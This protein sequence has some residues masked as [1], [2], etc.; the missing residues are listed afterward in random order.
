MRAVT[1]VPLKPGSVDLTDL[2]EPPESDGPVL[3]K[4]RAIGVCGTDLEII[5]GEYG[6][7]P[8]GE[9]RLGIGHESLGEVLDAPPDSGFSAGDLVVGI[10][11]RPDPVPCPNCAVGEWDMCRNGKY[12]EWGIKEHHGFARERYRITPEF[13]VKIDS[14]LG[15]LGV[16]LEPTTILAKAWDH[17]ERIGARAVWSPSTALIIGAG[18]IGLLAALL[19]RQRG[20]EVHVLDQVPEGLK[21]DLVAAL[22]ATY[23]HGS[24]AD[25]GISPDVAIECTGVGQLIFDVMDTAGPNGIVCLTGVSSGGRELSLDVGTLNR[26]MVLEND[27]VFGSVNANHRHY[28]AGADALSNAD[29]EWLSRLITRRV[30]LS[31]WRGAYE[32]KPTD[33]KVVLEFDPGPKR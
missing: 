14:S 33:V 32:R 4:T 1:V 7:P 22:G 31:D 26:R 20:L 11:R 5:N 17:I 28:Q 9:E 13:L 15:N 25:V 19:G 8:P 27:V 2:P 29:H 3:V 30:P 21:P 18:P 16:L 24:V 6:W 23:H 12:T 10:V